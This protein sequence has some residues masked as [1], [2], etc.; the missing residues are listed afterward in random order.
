MPQF[1]FYSFRNKFF[2]PLF[3]LL[4]LK[5]YCVNFNSVFEKREFI[6]GFLQRYKTDFLKCALNYLFYVSLML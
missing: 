1:D 5:G 2:E 6:F 3:F 4:I